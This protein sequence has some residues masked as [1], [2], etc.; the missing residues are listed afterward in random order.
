MRQ[1]QACD[2]QRLPVSMAMR[3]HLFSYRTQK[4][5]SSAQ[6]VLGWTRPGRVCRRRFPKQK[7]STSVGCFC[8]MSDK[9]C[10]RFVMLVLCVVGFYYWILCAVGCFIL[11]P[12]MTQFAVSSQARHRGGKFSD[13]A[14]D[15]RGMRSAEAEVIFRRAKEYTAPRASRNRAQARVTAKTSTVYDADTCPGEYVD[16]GFQNK[17]TQHQLGAFALYPIMSAAGLLCSYCT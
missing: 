17:S 15:R 16:A 14:A 8:F 12:T 10:S 9:K 5:S 7:H 1:A 11:P 2:L 4:L 3:S 13:R 6:M